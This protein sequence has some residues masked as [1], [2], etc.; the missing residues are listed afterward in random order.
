MANN[1]NNPN[2]RL[3]SEKFYDDQKHEVHTVKIGKSFMWQCDTCPLVDGRPRRDK[4]WT[5]RTSTL[6]PEPKEEKKDEKNTKTGNNSS[7]S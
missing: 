3:G 6:P 1:K 2:A 7:K 5:Y 4:T